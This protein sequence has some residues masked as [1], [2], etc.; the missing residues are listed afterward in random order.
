MFSFLF[1]RSSKPKSV[2]RPH[3]RSKPKFEGLED[4]TVPATFAVSSTADAGDG[5]LRDAIAK[6]N[7]TPGADVVE[8][9]HYDG[10]S[11]ITLT[12]GEIAVTDDVMIVG[13]GMDSTV[14]GSNRTSRIFN[15]EGNRSVT[16]KLQDLMLY[17]GSAQGEGG[18]VRVAGAKLETSKVNFLQNQADK[19]GAV[20]LVDAGG[21]AGEA[22]FDSTIFN[23]NVSGTTGGA[24]YLNSNLPAP[25]GNHA[26]I[27][28]SNFAFNTSNSPNGGGGAIAV[29][30][31]V[32]NIHGSSIILNT[33]MGDGGGIKAGANS[34]V[35]VIGST[36]H[37]NAATT[38]LGGGGIL[39]SGALTISNS[40]ITQ[41]NDSSNN[42]AG[43]VR[44]QG[45]A[46]M[47]LSSTIIAENIGVYG[48]A[49]TDLRT[50]MAVISDGHNLVK[51]SAGVK[52][53]TG[54]DLVNVD[55]LLG[56]AQYNGSV[57]GTRVPLA[58]SPVIGAGSNPYGQ[59]FDQR[60]SGFARVT[61]GN[62]DIG[63]V[64]FDA[65]NVAPTATLSYAPTVAMGST[66]TSYDLV[67]KYNDE[68][69]FNLAT[70]DSYDVVVTGPNGY[71][72]AATLI[73]TDVDANGPEIYANYRITPPGGV[74]TPLTN[75][76]YTV[77]LAANQAFDAKGRPV[78]GGTLGTFE[79]IVYGDTVGFVE[80]T[81]K[82]VL[83]RSA[84]ATSLQAYTDRL[85]N[86]ESRESVAREIWDSQEHRQAQ[87]TAYYQQ[88]LGRA[89]DESGMK[90]WV[91]RLMDGASEEEV[92][93]AILAS[94]EKAQDQSAGATVT[95]NFYQSLFGRKA[96]DLAADYAAKID[97]GADAKEVAKELA[98]SA[99]R[100]ELEIA[101]LYQKVLLRQPDEVGRGE[102]A[103]SIQE[104]GV[105]DAA[106][107]MLASD[108]YF[109]LHG[110][111]I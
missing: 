43:G 23:R 49:S 81:Y 106:V 75:G 16:M 31:G 62:V 6:A 42:G 39:A 22:L 77:T 3:V 13:H 82:S 47:L 74:W 57:T 72:Q 15:V 44:H 32:L 1:G 9:A 52:G 65:A 34:S 7:S 97:S 37:Q 92:S 55:P 87:V 61:Q 108:E 17:Q 111:K 48:E 99:E 24:L 105:A 96:D 89:P 73:Q 107:A 91:D 90:Y 45:T 53:L 86:G 30:S 103:K 36:I 69:A 85:N 109:Q 46:G 67:V 63:A 33:S 12:T 4:R 20:A 5:S 14:I 59:V 94:K 38:G 83:N 26:V 79:V 64:Q 76:V 18:A 78:A 10:M 28:N 84:D 25:S 98:S 60:G 66:T 40:T 35:A 11:Q 93:A 29:E 70:I 51:K 41:N 110:S 8:I 68:T 54:T 101:A 21:R 19:G 95:N 71:K 58:G 27:G 2:K 100:V 80:A 56:P 50:L 104:R 88:L 102:W